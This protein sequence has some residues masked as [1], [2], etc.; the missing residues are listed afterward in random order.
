[1]YYVVK[2]DATCENCGKKYTGFMGHICPKN[3]AS[4][5]GDTLNAA[6]DSIDARRI[7]KKVEDAVR[8]HNY[9]GMEI[10]PNTCP[11]CGSYQTWNPAVK[12]VKP[13]PNRVTAKG[14]IGSSLFL[15]I[16]VVPAFIILSLISLLTPLNDL[17][18]DFGILYFILLGIIV[19]FILGKRLCKS[20]IISDEEYQKKL[21]DYED[22]M[23]WYGK[24]D[25]ALK[26][27]TVHNLPDA[28]LSSG[29][30]TNSDP[31]S[32]YLQGG[33]KETNGKYCPT[34]HK[35]LH[36]VVGMNSLELAR[37]RNHCCPWCGSALPANIQLNV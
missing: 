31:Y 3:D 8:Y 32:V 23:Q 24:V 34:C 21:K 29:K 22:E 1:M 2:F 15:S 9:E 30:F 11:A 35:K 16:F 18:G 19:S 12:P 33:V 27:R 25:S 6:A 7:K 10:A 20:E 13:E 36:G 17:L 14:V 28:S 5:L 37:A 26:N 4:L